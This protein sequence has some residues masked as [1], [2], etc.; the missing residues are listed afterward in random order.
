[1]LT[2][3]Q[4][5]RRAATR[6]RVNTMGPVLYEDRWITCEADRLIIRGYYPWGPKV[7]AYRDILAVTPQALN[8]WTGSWRIWGTTDPRYWFHL[9]FNRPRKQTALILELGKPVRPVITPDDSGL[10]AAIIAQQRSG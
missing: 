8:F 4:N 9:D 5:E 2:T 10:V 1:M 3:D 7:I 6:P